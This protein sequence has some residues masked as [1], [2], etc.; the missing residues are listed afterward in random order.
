MSERRIPAEG[1][2]AWRGRLHFGID[3]APLQDSIEAFA[4]EPVSLRLPQWLRRVVSI[5]DR[6]FRKSAGI[7]RRGEG[8]APH[9]RGSAISRTAPR[10]ACNASSAS[11]LTGTS[12]TRSF[13]DESSQSRTDRLAKALESAVVER[14]RCAAARRQ[15]WSPSATK[16]IPVT[17]PKHARNRRRFR[18]RGQGNA[19][20]GVYT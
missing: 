7:T 15:I 18:D 12:G 8:V 13:S 19:T 3:R 9:G 20:T 16:P 4:A 5:P 1:Y 6:A 14:G 2:A 10:E 17:F 11:S